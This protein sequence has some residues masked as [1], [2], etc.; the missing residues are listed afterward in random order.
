MLPNEVLVK[1]EDKE[2]ML[3]LL[4]EILQILFNYPSEKESEIKGCI[5]TMMRAKVTAETLSSYLINLS[6]EQKK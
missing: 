1:R 3:D 6:T 4:D 5:T 2:R